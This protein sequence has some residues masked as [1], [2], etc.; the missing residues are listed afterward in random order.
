MNSCNSGGYLV[1]PDFWLPSEP[2]DYFRASYGTG[3]IGCNHLACARCGEL[4]RHTLEGPARR[5][6]CACVERDERGAT[7]LETSSDRDPDPV[8]PWHCAGH[9]AFVPPGVIA[10]VE[11]RNSLGWRPIVAEHIGDVSNL[12]PSIDLIP[13]FTL[14]RIFQALESEQDQR[15]L[16]MAVGGHGSD[17]TLRARQ[18][19]VLF[20][21]LNGRAQGLERVLDAWRDDPARYDDHPAGVGPH[22]L[23]K[24]AL[25]EATAMRI[26]GGAP[27]AKPAL[28]TW[29]WAALHGSGLG[30]N[31]HLA[32]SL[33]A[34]WANEHVEEML[35]LAPADWCRIVRAI[36]VA[37]PMRLVSGL[38]RA[39]DEGHATTEEVR[40]ALTEKYG[41][42]AEPIVAA[43][44]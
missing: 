24:D 34:E 7:R 3:S 14:T 36:H 16:A 17:P 2:S 5:Y 18:A 40:V 12:H 28:A 38:R 42:K 11:V 29:R 19:A 31:L 15:A 33:D 39:I 27:E 1:G 44:G 32:R 10:G 6:R 20:Y 8:P 41:A 9:P 26:I 23:L 13:G 4:V 22:P 25:L 30:V 43:L 35:D 21:A 37:F